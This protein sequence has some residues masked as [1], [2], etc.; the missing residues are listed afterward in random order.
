MKKTILIFFILSAV[1][2][3]S[4]AQG[5]KNYSESDDTL[6]VDSGEDF[7][8]SLE[9]NQV[10]GSR[11]ELAEP[12]N[13]EMLSLIKIGYVPGFARFQGRGGKEIWTLKAISPG[14]T[15]ISLRYPGKKK[16]FMVTIKEMKAP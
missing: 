7:S 1:L 12:L 3:S 13:W 9:A 6:E 8:I 2:S 16:V 10:T 4:L 15:V 14:K 5:P 11:W